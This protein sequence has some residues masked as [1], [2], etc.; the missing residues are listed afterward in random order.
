MSES[1]RDLGGG[2]ADPNEAPDCDLRCDGITGMS[3]DPN[4][5]R[6]SVV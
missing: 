5:D 1:Y 2:I 4:P 6:K 3:R